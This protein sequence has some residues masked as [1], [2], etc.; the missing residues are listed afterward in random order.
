MED[1]HQI[2]INH[3]EKSNKFQDEAIKKLSAIE[4]H[5]QYTKE[6]LDNHTTHIEDY[7]K[8][9]SIIYGAMI[10]ISA[11]WGFFLWLFKRT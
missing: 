9:K 4:T 1:L 5:N 7:K 2:L 3:I 6:T 10:S 11:I 8:H